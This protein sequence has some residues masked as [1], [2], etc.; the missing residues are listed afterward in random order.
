MAYVRA[1]RG[2]AFLPVPITAAIVPAGVAFVP[3]EG[4]PHGQ[5][6]LAWDAD[7]PPEHIPGLLNAARTTSGDAG[8]A[9]G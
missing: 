1:G 3:V 5:V 7:R 6:V 4:I 9:G 2:V 8:A